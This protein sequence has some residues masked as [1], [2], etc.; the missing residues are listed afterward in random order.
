[1][2]PRLGLGEFHTTVP[3]TIG[4]ERQGS[5]TGVAPQF[6]PQ[7][8]NDTLTNASSDEELVPPAGESAI[9]GAFLC[10][11][12]ILGAQLPPDLDPRAFCSTV[13]Y[14]TFSQSSREIV[15][16]KPHKFVVHSEQA[17]AQN[18]VRI[19]L[20]P[21]G[22]SSSLGFETYMLLAHVVERFGLGPGRC[23]ALGMVPCGS[24][25]APAEIARFCAQ[26]LAAEQKEL[27]AFAARVSL[28]CSVVQTAGSLWH[29]ETDLESSSKD[30]P[31]ADDERP[32]Q[33]DAEPQADMGD[34]GVLPGPQGLLAM[35]SEAAEVPAKETQ[36]LSAPSQSFRD[37][38]GA[39]AA[40]S[41]QQGQQPQ[42]PGRG[43]GSPGASAAWHEEQEEEDERQWLQEELKRARN[44]L[45]MQQTLMNFQERR[46]QVFEAQSNAIA[47]AG[48]ASEAYEASERFAG[49]YEQLRQMSETV[50]MQ[51][52]EIMHLREQLAMR[53]Q[54][55][56]QSWQQAQLRVRLEH[57][58]QECQA[59]MA[60]EVDVRDH[61]IAEL[62]MALQERE[63]QLDMI[64]DAVDSILR[65]PPRL[66]GEESVVSPEPSAV[67]RS[68]QQSAG[69]R[70]AAG[71]AFG[72]G[73]T[74]AMGFVPGEATG[75]GGGHEEAATG[76]PP[77]PRPVAPQWL[78][79][80]STAFQG[81]ASFQGPF[82]APSHRLSPSPGG[83]NSVL[84]AAEGGGSSHSSAAAVAGGDAAPS[85]KPK[86]GSSDQKSSCQGQGVAARAA[87][88]QAL[89]G[90]SG[91]SAAGWQKPVAAVGAPAVGIMVS[92]PSCGPQEMLAD[93]TEAPAPAA[94][95]HRG[96][97]SSPTA[98]TADIH[99][100][101]TEDINA[102]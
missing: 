55:D 99:S 93:S 59:Q 7:P 96:V 80:G 10:E 57:A 45:R 81:G 18:Y 11:V 71:P 60:Y 63:R 33:L 14:T 34:R 13:A 76:G 83:V 35:A 6:A 29:S 92:Q 12:S 56:A 39:S 90:G 4:N 31:R 54:R 65:S 25:A 43:G 2:P 61:R 52:D 17:L 8:A 46:L 94:D 42:S 41:A 101:S 91:S 100:G 88:A 37:P 66:L 87:P 72:F 49:V 26:P 78:G 21:R 74:A 102:L 15:S 23:V 28:A 47:A 30:W 64:P 79:Q 44:E 69:F 97:L 20:E 85:S 62:E 50:Q 70:M 48:A 95:C 38:P 53:T 32:L 5:L 24:G 27:G 51:Q 36:A 67:Y 73:P 82:P 3:T 77:P 40:A 19:G 9:K 75:S 58:L 22:S 1:M 68:A 89:A 86:P 16:Q 98:S 84:G